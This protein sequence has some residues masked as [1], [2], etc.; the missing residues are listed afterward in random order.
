MTT[1]SYSSKF[2]PLYIAE[3]VLYTGEGVNLCW[4]GNLEKEKDTVH[5]RGAEKVEK[6]ERG[7]LSHLCF[8]NLPDIHRCYQHCWQCFCTGERREERG[9]KGRV[10]PNLYRNMHTN[11]TSSCV[12]AT[13]H[14]QICVGN[15][16]DSLM[17]MERL[18]RYINCKDFITCLLNNP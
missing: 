16:V 5:V 12:K 11:N 9:G 15:T 13:P 6:K 7:V 14:I 3:R 2:K 4:E 18:F 8:G 1:T 10:D 17:K